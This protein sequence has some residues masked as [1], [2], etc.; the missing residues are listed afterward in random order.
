MLPE[1]SKSSPLKKL[2]DLSKKNCGVVCSAIMIGMIAPPREKEVLMN[3][4]P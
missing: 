2:L 3:N 1:V 4:D